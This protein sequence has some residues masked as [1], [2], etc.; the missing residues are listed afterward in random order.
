MSQKSWVSDVE[1]LHA[2]FGD[3]P[4]LVA[5]LTPELREKF[6]G[7]RVRFL[8]EELT[9][10]I[11]ADTP[12]DVVDALIDLCVVAIGTLHAFGVDTSRA[13]DVV[14]RANIVKIPGPNP[15]RPNPFGFPDL[16][17]PD[18]WKAP[19]HAGNVGVITVPI[20]FVADDTPEVPS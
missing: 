7:F 11:T 9:E 10:L 18:G 3:M 14:Y 4:A 20:Q 6:L 13:W 8:Y 5:A 17:K 15:T 16:L 19:T 12:E 2:K 1:E